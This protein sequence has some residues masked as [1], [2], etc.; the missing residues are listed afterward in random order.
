MGHTFTIG[1]PSTERREHGEHA[2]V[3][4][5]VEPVSTPPGEEPVHTDPYEIERDAGSG[6]R[7]PSF[8]VWGETVDTFPEFQSVW[9]SIREYATENYEPAYIPVS[10]YVDDLPGVID[11]ATTALDDE[12]LEPVAQRV[13][14]FCR[15]SQYAHERHRGMAVF[16]SSEPLAMYSY[17]L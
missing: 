11:V 17:G 1:H 3:K 14:W 2:T 15:W 6:E 12:E 10:L 4:P 8:R 5:I 9:F 7:S 13:L 16:Q